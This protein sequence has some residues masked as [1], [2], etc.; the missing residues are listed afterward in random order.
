MEGHMK[1][2][3]FVNGYNLGE[4]QTFIC[5]DDRI[6]AMPHDNHLC[7]YFLAVVSKPVGCYRGVDNSCLT[8]SSLL[9]DATNCF[10]EKE[11]F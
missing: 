9:Q 7:D 5:M 4:I 6:S 11:P 3:L 1:C 8:D 10:A 2:E